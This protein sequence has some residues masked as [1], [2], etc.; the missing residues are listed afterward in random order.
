[1]LIQESAMSAASLYGA[2]QASEASQRLQDSVMSEVSLSGVLQASE[3]LHRFE[4][5]IV[6]VAGVSGLLDA[7]ET[8]LKIQESVVSAAS[9]PVVQQASEALQKFHE[10]T[11]S[12]VSMS[13]VIHHLDMVQ[14]VQDLAVSTG[15]IAES[16]YD[17]FVDSFSSAF[18]DFNLPAADSALMRLQDSVSALSRSAADLQIWM[19]D[20]STH[21]MSAASLSGIGG[22]TDV[23]H[24]YQEP[25]RA[26][27]TAAS[28]AEATM[29]A[30]QDRLAA[31]L[32]VP[33]K[34]QASILESV[35]EA[36]TGRIS[37]YGADG[38]DELPDPETLQSGELGDASQFVKLLEI[39]VRAGEAVLAEFVTSWSTLVSRGDLD[40][41]DVRAATR[42]F[43][44]LLFMVPGQLRE[45]LF[46][47]R[48]RV[49]RKL[50]GSAPRPALPVVDGRS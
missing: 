5:S 2:Y 1:M 26:V 12:A 9:M 10:V 36:D 21:L 29:T 32:D 15:A 35:L 7:S 40:Q 24:E 20:N 46:H 37:P 11:L 22:L 25:F 4:D 50:T 49:I 23:L 47:V 45:A 6:P 30:L 39:G 3:A 27:A 48:A 33:A 42:M 31:A 28:A 44:E 34:L 14:Q 16:A 13:G 17:G 41:R 8:L 18:Q 43:D 38:L 19:P